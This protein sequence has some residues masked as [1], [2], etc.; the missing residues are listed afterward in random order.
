MKI[1][2]TASGDTLES[3]I[4]PRFGRAP[5]FII[6]NPETMEFEAVDNQSAGVMSGA[7]I[8]AAQTVANKGAELV[9][10]GNVGPNAFRALSS[11]GIKIV[12]GADS[13][14]RESIENYKKGTLEETTNATVGGHFGRKGATGSGRGMGRGAG[15]GQGRRR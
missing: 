14:V 8:Q 10:T 1:C 13:T 2:V 3:A 9:I 12:V 5:Y 11:A 7:G 4:D 6:V 15:S